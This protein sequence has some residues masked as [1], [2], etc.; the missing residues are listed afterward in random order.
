MDPIEI[1]YEGMAWVHLAQDRENWWALVN[2]VM[3]LQVPQKV[4]KLLISQTTFNFSKG[5]MLQERNSMW[6]HL[7][8]DG[9]VASVFNTCYVHYL[10]SHM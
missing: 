6:L 4:G 2:I 1:W 10:S 8:M 7:Q 9:I 5:I 3:N